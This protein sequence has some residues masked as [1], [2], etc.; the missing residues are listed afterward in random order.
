[1]A[2]IQKDDNDCI[3][4]DDVM[5][6]KI[7]NMDIKSLKDKFNA[8]STGHTIDEEGNPSK[9]AAPQENLIY[10]F[11]DEDLS[12]QAALKVKEDMVKIFELQ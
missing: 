9:K 8:I 2:T 11:V 10:E 12:G 7:E 6:E 4:F 5:K 1:M 3:N